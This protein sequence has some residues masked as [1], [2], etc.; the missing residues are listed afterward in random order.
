MAKIDE[1]KNRDDYEDMLEYGH[2]MV[3]AWEEYT[4]YKLKLQEKMKGTSYDWQK[5]ATLAKQLDKLYAEK[6]MPTGEEN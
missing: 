6:Y 2:R 1:I 5:P 4:D 3:E